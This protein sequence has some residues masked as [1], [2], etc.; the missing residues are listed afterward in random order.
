MIDTKMGRLVYTFIQFYSHKIRGQR[1]ITYD[2]IKTIE[3]RDDF[4]KRQK[5]FTLVYIIEFL[6]HYT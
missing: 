1:V 6:H 4:N 2:I 5:D 3:W